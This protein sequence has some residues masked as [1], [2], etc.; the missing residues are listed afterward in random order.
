MS[1]YL[2]KHLVIIAGEVVP[3]LRPVR[4]LE[5][6]HHKLSILNLML[7]H[8]LVDEVLCLGHSFGVTHELGARLLEPHEAHH[9]DSVLTLG[10]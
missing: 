5:V 1:T 7:L 9:A 6:P 8:L 4:I 10:L 2:R 3:E